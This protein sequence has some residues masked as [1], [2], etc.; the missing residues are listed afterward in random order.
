MHEIHSVKL[1][2]AT[3]PTAFAA[4]SFPVDTTPDFAD[5]VPYFSKSPPLTS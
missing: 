2:L 4:V 5:K 3:S 1:D